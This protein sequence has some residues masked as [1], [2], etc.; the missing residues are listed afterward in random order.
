MEIFV[1]NLRRSV[2][3]RDLISRQLD[4][5]GL[6][7]RIYEATDGK[8]LDEQEL[9]RH[10]GPQWEQVNLTAGQIGCALSHYGV[11][12]QMVAE[13]IDTALI[14]EDDLQLSPD[15]PLLL[16]ALENQL[17][18]DEII[19]LYFV[20]GRGCQ[21]TRAD[22]VALP[23]G[24]QLRFPMSIGNVLSATAYLLK[25]ST[26]R[27]LT[28]TVYPIHLCADWWG[29]MHAEGSLERIRCVMPS[30]IQL[31]LDL[32]SDIGL[33]QLRNPAIR[34][35]LNLIQRYEIFPLN[36]LLTWNRS[37]VMAELQAMCTFTDQPS[38]L[39]PDRDER[40]PSG[41]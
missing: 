17:R 33:G 6:P 3:R 39:R 5:L 18:V 22:E 11:Y 23:Q 1:I 37:R 28:E 29:N 30:P 36:R 9:R 27:K 24:Y 15:L 13:N 14:L 38:P 16:P 8:A 31:R 19:L 41:L 2:K 32:P 40:T 34:T 20:P 35:V 21:V 26:A 25:N 7:Y 10:C 12:Q 4:R